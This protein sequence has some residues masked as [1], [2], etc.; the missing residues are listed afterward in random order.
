MVSRMA[1]SLPTFNG[2][3]SRVRCFPHVINLIARSILAQFDLPNKKAN[4]EASHKRLR[5]ESMR[6]ENELADLELAELD[7]NGHD[8]GKDPMNI[9]ESL[10]GHDE[11]L[12][13]ELKE[14]RSLAG[15]LQ[16]HQEL[17]RVQEAP[18]EIAND[19][20][21]E[22]WIDERW[23]MVEDDLATLTGQVMPVRRVLVKVSFP[24]SFLE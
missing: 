20:E 11:S 23:S 16:E 21:D 14:L 2:E 9:D 13:E 3:G 10:A 5:E 22:G 24:P 19:M 15:N 18:E 8:I 4:S 1:D 7:V 6:E 17:Q 12:V